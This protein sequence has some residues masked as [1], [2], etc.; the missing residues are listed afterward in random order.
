MTWFNVMILETSIDGSNHKEVDLSTMEPY[1]S[2]KGIILH[3]TITRHD[4]N[5]NLKTTQK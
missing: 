3:H 1:K 2:K 4:F 5:F